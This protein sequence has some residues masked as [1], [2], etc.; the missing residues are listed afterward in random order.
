[1]QSHKAPTYLTQHR[2][3][4]LVRA[5]EDPQPNWYF[6]TFTI[7]K[8]AIYDLVAA[9]Y[10]AQT[11]SITKT[12]MAHS[13]HIPSSIGVQIKIVL[14]DRLGGWFFFLMWSPMLAAQA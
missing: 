9:S 7:D 13:L 8:T 5:G 3:L 12:S 6:S 1:M 2:C 14:C 11:V 4:P 10:D